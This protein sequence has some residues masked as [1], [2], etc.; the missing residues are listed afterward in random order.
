MNLKVT[1]IR[2]NL[3]TSNSLVTK[4]ATPAT[5]PPHFIANNLALDFIN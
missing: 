5:H 3:S 4:M 2:C 1:W